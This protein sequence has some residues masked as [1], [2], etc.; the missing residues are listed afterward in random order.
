[1]VKDKP[2]PNVYPIIYSP[3]YVTD[4]FETFGQNKS[5]DIS[6]DAYWGTDWIPDQKERTKASSILTYAYNLL[7]DIKLL[8]NNGGVLEERSLKELWQFASNKKTG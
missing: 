6:N 3:S 7:G 5:S 1:M 4:Q 2:V 8:V